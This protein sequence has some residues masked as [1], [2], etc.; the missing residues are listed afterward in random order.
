[1]KRLFLLITLL[2]VFACQKDKI[3]PPP[4]DYV[5]LYSFEGNALDGSGNNNHGQ[6]NRVQFTSGVIGQCPRFNPRD[7]PYI[8]IPFTNRLN[9]APNSDFTIFLFLKFGEQ[10]DV[11]VHDNYILSMWYPAKVYSWT[12]RILNQNYLRAPLSFY[13]A[14]YDG[15]KNDPTL[16]YPMKIGDDQWHSVAVVKKGTDLFLFLDG[17]QVAKTLDRTTVAC[18]TQNSSDIYIGCEH[19]QQNRVWFDG[20]IDEL[21]FYDYALSSSQVEALANR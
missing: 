1:M 9:F 4:T 3:T 12:L 6:L 10:S 21:A 5:A 18:G 15:C 2:S 19:P 16:T 17:K 20:S 7:K 14:R 8:K 11:T 13:A